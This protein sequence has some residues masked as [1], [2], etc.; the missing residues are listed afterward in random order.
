MPFVPSIKAG[1]LDALTRE[2]ETSIRNSA[3][4]VVGAIAKQELA[5]RKWPELLECAQQLCCQGKLNERGLGLYDT[6][7]AGDELKTFLKP[8]VSIFHSALQDPGT[9]SAYYAGM[10]L[11]NLIPY[12]G[13][14]EAVRSVY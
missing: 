1:L 13:T 7:V 14:E 9:G 3:A 8:F 10:T 4:Q 11:K 6:D 5:Y 12:I 2:T